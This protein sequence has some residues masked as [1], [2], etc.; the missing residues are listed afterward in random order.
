MGM[1]SKMDMGQRSPVR[2][3]WFLVPIDLKKSENTSV[4][5]VLD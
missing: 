3:P 2:G 4:F 5:V 1:I